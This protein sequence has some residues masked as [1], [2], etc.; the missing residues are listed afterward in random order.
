MR[1]PHR[2]PPL[3]PPPGG[4][5]FAFLALGLA[6]CV[7]SQRR[8]ADRG[9]PVRGVRFRV[10]ARLWVTGLLLPVGGG[11]E[12]RGHEGEPGASRPNRPVGLPVPEDFVDG[13][14]VRCRD[15]EAGGVGTSL[16]DVS[17]V[18]RPVVWKQLQ[19]KGAPAVAPSP[20]GPS[21]PQHP[22]A[23]AAQRCPLG[24][25]VVAWEHP[26]PGPS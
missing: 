23:L 17:W 19:V 1:K 10:V 18:R 20:A 11:G 13:R 6:H 22:A 15:R 16:R 12:R 7:P 9:L 2:V 4:S 25:C 24:L 8:L 5:G 21:D 26:F 3:V 14:W